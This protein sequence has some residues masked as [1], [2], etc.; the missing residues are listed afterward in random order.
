M[1]FCGFVECSFLRLWEVACPYSSSSQA[2]EVFV[3]NL[4]RA[5]GAQLIDA[6]QQCGHASSKRSV[7]DEL[8]V[9]QWREFRTFRG[10]GNY[11]SLR[12]ADDI[13]NLKKV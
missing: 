12:A 7:D 2:D 11:V 1:G 10:S 6:K 5:C 4:V 3:A 9:I 8:P 13:R